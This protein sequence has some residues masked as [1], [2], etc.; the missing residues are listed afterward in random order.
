MEGYVDGEREAAQTDEPSFPP[1]LR[2]FHFLQR[3]AFWGA[4][5]AAP[6]SF[7]CLHARQLRTGMPLSKV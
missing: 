6:R 5:P 7:M 1:H 4:V 3:Q 2:G